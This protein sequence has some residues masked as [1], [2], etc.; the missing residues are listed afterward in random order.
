MPPQYSEVSSESVILISTSRYAVTRRGTASEDNSK[1]KH[2]A[3]DAPAGCDFLYAQNTCMY[4]Y[5]QH[6]HLPGRCQMNS[7]Q[8]GSVG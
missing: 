8:A 6:L 1:A 7:Y 2:V 4:L 3:F 5:A